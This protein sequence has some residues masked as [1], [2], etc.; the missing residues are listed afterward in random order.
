MNIKVITRHGPSNYGSLLQSIATVAVLKQL[1]HSVRIIDYQREDER[2][3][4][5]IMT[6]VSQKSKFSSPLKRVAYILTRYPIE[7]YAQI[8]FDAMRKRL[9]P[10][11]KRYSTHDGLC[12][13]EADLFVTGSDQVWG[14]MMNGRLDT[15]YFLDFV[16]AN[17]RKIAFS[18]SFGK[19]T[20]NSEM[21]SCFYHLLSGYDGIAVR[22]DTAVQ[23]LEKW[24]LK[25][26]VGQVLD[27]TLLLN[28]LDWQ[29][30]L[31]L[32]KK[33]SST[34]EKYILLYLIHNYPEHSRY[35]VEFA[36]RK[37]MK[38]VRV[39]PFFHQI[40]SGGR[41]I[42]CPQVE[43]FVSLIK[44]ATYMVTDSFHGTCFAINFN[45]QFLE[46]LP[47]NGTSTRNTSILHLVG[48]S[49]R[50]VTDY[51]V[52]TYADTIIN[53]QDVNSI[54]NVERE[55]SFKVLKMLLNSK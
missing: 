10:L 15:A 48:L 35:A 18:A 49:N 33:D 22:E 20:I 55:K 13:I 52:F 39:N 26:C 38:L 54:L 36:K 29:K 3:V 19:Q 7:K 6:Q 14:P 16:E 27:P 12:N 4:S 34:S 31:Q 47:L 23:L 28:C 5:M 2:G 8:K 25:N 32:D 24:G 51:N 37:G 9:L 40:L 21:G 17:K 53:Y 11:T 43:R 44:N 1:G 45:I 41:F 30:E 42:C 50:I 46:M